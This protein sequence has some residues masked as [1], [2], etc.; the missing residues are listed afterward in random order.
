MFNDIKLV[1]GHIFV[2]LDNCRVS[3]AKTTLDVCQPHI[4]NFKFPTLEVLKNGENEKN[5]AF[6]ELSLFLKNEFEGDKLV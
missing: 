4:Q 1:D 3:K 6:T 2:M 5:E